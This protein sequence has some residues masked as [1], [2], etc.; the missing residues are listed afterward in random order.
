M[1]GVQLM[2]TATPQSPLTLPRGSMRHMSEYS[3]LKNLDEMSLHLTLHVF[4]CKFLFFVDSIFFQTYWYVLIYMN[5]LVL[6][7]NE[8]FVYGHIPKFIYIYLLE[9]DDTYSTILNENNY[10]CIHH[11]V[12]F[13]LRLIGR[14]YFLFFSFKV[15]AIFCS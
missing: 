13:L 12:Q 11:D 6:Q 10:N 2:A 3:D 4:Y 7:E 9:L 5:I 15:L 14:I 1:A 8:I